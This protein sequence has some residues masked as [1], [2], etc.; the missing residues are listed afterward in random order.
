[1][2]DGAGVCRFKDDHPLSAPYFGCVRKHLSGTIPVIE[3]LPK[4]E[5]RK[6]I[7]PTVVVHKTPNFFDE[8]ATFSIVAIAI[9]IVTVDMVE[10]PA[11]FRSARIL[12]PWFVVEFLYGAVDHCL[13]IVGHAW[14][15]SQQG[16]VAYVDKAH[17][18][19]LPLNP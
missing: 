17:D 5:R 19:P 6:N 4:I 3:V 12:V 14:M 18:L 10:C 13:E 11:D 1:M 15:V 9:D 7:L 2:T 16:A 8:H